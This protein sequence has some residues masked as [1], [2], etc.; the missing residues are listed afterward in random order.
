MTIQELSERKGL[1]IQAVYWQI[2]N[3]KGWGRFFKRGKDGRWKI[4]GR[5]VR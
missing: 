5:L 2:K 1:T 3:K 4:D